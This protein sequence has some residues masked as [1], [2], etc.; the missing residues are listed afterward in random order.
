MSR[1][2]VLLGRATVLNDCEAVA[3]NIDRLPLAVIGPPESAIEG[4]RPSVDP[5]YP[6]RGV[7][8]AANGKALQQVS[9]ELAPDSLAPGPGRTY[10]A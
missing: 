5:N 1:A 9:V 6:D 10:N 2:G 3:S 4:H 8:S 7:F